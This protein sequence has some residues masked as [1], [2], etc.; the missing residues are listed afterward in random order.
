MIFE[1][2]AALQQARKTKRFSISEFEKMYNAEL[3]L[4]ARAGRSGYD[5]Y[6]VG[7]G[8]SRAVEVRGARLRRRYLK[9]PGLLHP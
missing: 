8:G 6:L 5:P 9:H 7:Y 2:S 4:M 3:R 1:F